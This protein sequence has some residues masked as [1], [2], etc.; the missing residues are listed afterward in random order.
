MRSHGF[1]STIGR[2]MIAMTYVSVGLLVV[3]VV[4]MLVNGISP[5]DQAPVFDPSLI[6]AD[7]LAGMPVG[8]LWLGLILVIATPIVRV[9]ASAV[10]YAREGQWRMVGVGTGILFVIAV[11]I[12]TSI[13]VEH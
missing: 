5:L 7:L 13:A 3:G 6:W 12:V 2:L 8:F 1:E 11:G 4:L 10:G 9:A